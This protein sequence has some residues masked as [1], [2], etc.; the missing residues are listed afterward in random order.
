M[1]LFAAPGMKGT[2]TMSEDPLQI[3]TPGF[4]RRRLLTGAAVLGGA[5][6]AS[7]ALPP[8]LR[9]AVA[10]TAPKSVNLKEIKHVVLAMQ[11]NRSFDHYY[12]TLPGVRGFADPT[13]ITI[14]STR[15]SVF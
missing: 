13:A 4:S 12:G 8:N 2:G 10:A 7:V 15:E 11:E 14:A 5:A 9:K 6:A 3:Q 1:R